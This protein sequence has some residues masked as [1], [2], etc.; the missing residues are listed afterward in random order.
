VSWARIALAG[1][2]KA[3]VDVG[4]V[5]FVAVA[6]RVVIAICVGAANLIFITGKVREACISAEKRTARISISK[7]KPSKS[8][9][10]LA[11]RSETRLFIN[12]LR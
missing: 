11:V 4:T 2:V 7:M 12:K 1:S 9:P 6:S 8:K 10:I 5:N 3:L